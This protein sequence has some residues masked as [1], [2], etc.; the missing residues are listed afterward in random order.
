MNWITIHS[1]IIR[2]W[3]K[4]ISC[5]IN[6]LK[7]IHDPWQKKYFI[8]SFFV[9]RLHEYYIAILH[10]FL[11]V[12]G[13]FFSLKLFVKAIDFENQNLR[14]NKIYLQSSYRQPTINCISS[15]SRTCNKSLEA[16]NT[17]RWPLT[18]STEDYIQF[19]QKKGEKKSL[20]S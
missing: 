7:L 4:V 3:H 13:K 14:V 17:L 11:V 2:K 10:F 9:T 6:L 8:L 15:N 1:I 5:K 19:D 16:R 18:R 12:I 20:L